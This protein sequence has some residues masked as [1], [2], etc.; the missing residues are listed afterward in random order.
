MN[1]TTVREQLPL[2]IYCDLEQDAAKGIEAHLVDC[3]GC[4]AERTALA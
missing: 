4:R 3:A 2:F 1:C